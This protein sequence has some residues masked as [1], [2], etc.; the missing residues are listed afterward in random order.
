MNCDPNWAKGGSPVA[1]FDGLSRKRPPTLASLP[2]K[3]D[4]LQGQF[5]FSS[6]CHVGSVS[7]RREYRHVLSMVLP[8]ATKL[9]IRYKLWFVAYVFRNYQLRVTEPFARASSP[10]ARSAAWA[11]VPSSSF[12]FEW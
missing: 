4:V 3:F 5:R 10:N 2:A 7:R 1:D 9:R 8:K 11:V 6:I 12:S